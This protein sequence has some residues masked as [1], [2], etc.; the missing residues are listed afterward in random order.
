MAPMRP[1]L[2]DPN[3]QHPSFYN[4]NLKRRLPFHNP[5]SCEDSGKQGTK[6]GFTLKVPLLIGN[7]ANSSF[8][9]QVFFFISDGSIVIV[10]RCIIM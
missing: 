10:S 4:E 5:L 2:V 8:H 9:K 6:T 7:P 1:Y 3:L